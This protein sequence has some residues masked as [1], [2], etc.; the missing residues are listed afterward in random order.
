MNDTEL[1]SAA[2]EWDWCVVEG[3]LGREWDTFIPCQLRFA[4]E[5]SQDVERFHDAL[6]ARGYSPLDAER[7]ARRQTE[8]KPHYDGEIC[9]Q[10]HYNRIKVLVF[11]GGVVRL[12]PHDGY[13]P[14]VDELADVVEALEE[15]YQTE[16]EHDPIDHGDGE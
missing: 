10:E 9:S 3:Q 6:D 15:G 2:D 1:Q 12:Y 16:L 13:V 4:G 7:A 8:T 5:T 11:R 14:T